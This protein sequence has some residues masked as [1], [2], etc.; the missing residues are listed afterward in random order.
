MQ[1]GWLRATWKRQTLLV[2]RQD[3]SGRSWSIW[4]DNRRMTQFLEDVSIPIRPEIPA[5]FAREWSR[6]AAPGSYWSGRQRI[7]MA[8]T[9]REARA[10]SRNG[11]SSL[12]AAAEEAASLLGARPAGTSRSWVESTV[13]DLGSGPYIEI[14]G[15]VSRAVAVDTFHRAI[16]S[17]LPRLPEPV[18]GDPTGINDPAARSGPAWVPMVGGAS[19]VGALSAVPPEA[20]A[21]E[22]MH[23]P[24]YL[25][26][27]QMQDLEFVRGLSRPQMELVAARTSA[28]NECFY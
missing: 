27:Q 26:Y 11:N 19:I 12:P 17:P 14:V 4:C 20:E 28:I 7:E 15:V 24:L 18:A 22:D 21:Q 1:P 2:E 13:V 6:L 8:A 9:A 5:L 10:G 16:G 3:G 25:T 23:G